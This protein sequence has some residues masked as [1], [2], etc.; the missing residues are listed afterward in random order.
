MCS[1]VFKHFACH[2]HVCAN[3]KSAVSHGAVHILLVTK[4]GLC[5]VGLGW[6]GLGWVTNLG[7]VRA[8]HCKGIACWKWL[9]D[10]CNV[11]TLVEYIGSAADLR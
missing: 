11:L 6:L 2:E 4:M 10:L 9:P 5:W 1:A 3:A 8:F 7:L